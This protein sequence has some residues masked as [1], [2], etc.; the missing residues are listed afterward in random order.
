[1]RRMTGVGFIAVLACMASMAGADTSNQAVSKALA[2]RYADVTRAFQHRDSKA[3]DSIL[4]PDYFLKVPGGRVMTREMVEADFVSQMNAARGVTWR[5]RIEKLAVSGD[6]AVATVRG[7][8]RATIATPRG[9]PHKQE[10]DALTRD[11]W[12]KT[13]GTWKLKTSELLEMHTTLD[14]KPVGRPGG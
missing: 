8:F 12:A 1:M 11:T 4:A 9:Q 5:R 13:N 7:H 2:R 3:Y 6:E 10:L 14:G